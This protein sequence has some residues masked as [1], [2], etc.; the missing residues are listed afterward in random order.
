MGRCVAR[1]T[2]GEEPAAAV[3]PLLGTDVHCMGLTK[4]GQPRHPL[5]LRR[6]TPLNRLEWCAISSSAEE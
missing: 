4:D 6:D 3:L 2:T 5:Y 1:M